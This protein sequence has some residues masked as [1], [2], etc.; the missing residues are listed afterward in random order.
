M[1]ALSPK[2]GV[3]ENVEDDGAAGLPMQT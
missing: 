3:G 2:N 1:E